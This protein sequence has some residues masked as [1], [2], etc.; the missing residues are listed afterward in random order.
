MGGRRVFGGRLERIEL[1]FEARG[2]SFEFIDLTSQRLDHVVELREAMLLERDLDLKVL[3][4]L[5][6]AHDPLP[7]IL[8]DVREGVTEG[9]RGSHMHVVTQPLTPF[10]A[11]GGL[12]EVHGIRASQDNLVWLVVCQETGEAA[13]VD[14]PNLA[15]PEAYCTS[16]GVSPSVILNTH[17][18]GDHIGI[19]RD[20]VKEGRA[21][22]WRVAG[23]ASRA[24]DIPGLTEGLKP[25]DRVFVGAVEG[26]VID[27][28]GHLDGHIAYQFGDVLFCGDALFTGGCG[29]LF[30]GPPE[31]MFATLCR[32]AALP[33]DTRVCCAHEY[34]M[35]NL[36]FAWMVEPDN[37]ELARRIRDV[38]GARG[39]GRCVVPSRMSE[40]Q[41]T[42]PFLRPG[43][44]TL[45]A[46]LEELM[47]APDLSTHA[48]VFAAARR[49]KD[50]GTHRSI[51]DAMLPLDGDSDQKQ[52]R[53]DDV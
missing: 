23:P 6:C 48:A 9:A 26:R 3:N 36:R 17:T 38:W 15:E 4:A 50:T 42:N 49:L 16:V 35:D 31:R 44:A 34:T 1:L 2:L 11:C 33:G 47:D 30:D 29:Y 13:L 45:R 12:L 46:K 8:Q 7:V 24:A 40:E 25:G 5:V 39:E 14:G 22:G 32:L 28:Q 21:G 18:H 51:T 52:L 10:L 53:R 27:A 43:S 19:N 37:P 41:A 20:L